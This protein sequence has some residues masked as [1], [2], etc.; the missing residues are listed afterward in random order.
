[1]W[2]SRLEGSWGHDDR[3]IDWTE[4]DHKT[5]KC[6]L[7]FLYSGNYRLDSCQPVTSSPVQIETKTV[8]SD[9]E[10]AS[11]GRELPIESHMSYAKLCLEKSP[12]ISA[13][14]VMPDEIT[15]PVISVEDNPGVEDSLSD[16][17]GKACYKTSSSS[18]KTGEVIMAHSKVYTFADQFLCSKLKTLALHQLTL[19][20][21]SPSCH[22]Y[23]HIPALTEAAK[24]IYDNT[25][26]QIMD[27]DP[28][29][30]L[31]MQFLV[32]NLETVNDDLDILASESQFIQDLFRETLKH[33][34]TVKEKV[35]SLTIECT[36][37]DEA[38]QQFK[39][40]RCNKCRRLS[41]SPFK[42]E[43]R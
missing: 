14:N 31:L 6:V 22:V 7:S 36:Q 35:A 43:F 5:I 30:A 11:D 42:G 32:K 2:K 1:M 18:C 39:D 13:T 3:D 10:M 23:N 25:Q 9:E 27:S 16:D 24:Y 38:I 28:A 15:D 26:E 37:K 29:R 20:L 33:A 41:S 17:E 12:L 19:I 8:E 40:S 4:F 34:A 21:E